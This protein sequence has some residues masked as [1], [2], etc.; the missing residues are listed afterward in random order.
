MNR[1]RF[2]GVAAAGTA[3]VAATG[4]VCAHG[5]ST[6][7]LGLSRLQVPLPR[8]PA[9]L[10]GLRIAHLS[11]LHCGRDVPAEFISR[12]LAMATATRADL[13]VLT[14]D[15]VSYDWRNLLRVQDGLRALRAPL[16]V[17]A[18]LG[19]HDNSRGRAPHVTGILQDCGVRVLCNEA[20]PLDDAASAWLVG[21]GDPTTDQHDFDAALRD[22]PEGVCKV[23]LAHGPDIV[24]AAADL[25]LDLSLVGHTHGG[26]VNLPFIG[27]PVVPTRYGPRFAAGLFSVRGSRLF[28]T[29]GVGIVPPVGRYRCPPEVALLT[30]RRADWGLSS[31]APGLDLRPLIRATRD[32]I[33]LHRP[34]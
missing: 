28:V 17:F 19:N 26:Q 13:I 11:D 8:L 12:A 10:D 5:E 9:A 33:H 18:C 15:F 22:V 30:L 29:R 2:L 16:G 32:L 34:G 1:R 31:G 3:A 21:L 25:A 7:D 20:V 23:M 4:L 24:D 6:W 14:G 27:P